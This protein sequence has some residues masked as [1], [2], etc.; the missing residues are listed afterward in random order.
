LLDIAQASG[1]K[2][3]EQ[4]S[5]T[6]TKDGGVVIY[7]VGTDN[8]ITEATNRLSARLKGFCFPVSFL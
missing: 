1:G 8:I 2:P 4:P 5:T 6:K 7:K 3:K